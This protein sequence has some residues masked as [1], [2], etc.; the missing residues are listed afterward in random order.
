MKKF[1]V[2][3][4]KLIAKRQAKISINQRAFLFGD[5]FFETIKIC[6]HKI[7]NFSA[8]LRRI[9]KALEFL[10]FQAKIDDLEKNCEKLIAKNKVKNGLLR[11]HISRGDK[12]AG[13]AP[14]KNCKPLIIIETLKS[15]KL[16]KI[17][18]LGISS[19]CAPKINF[20]SGN[21]IFY[22]LNKLEAQKQKLFDLVMLDCEGFVS[23]TSSANIFWIKD[24]KIYTSSQS[25]N[26]ILGC[27]REKLLKN[28]NL[29]I[30]EK[31]AKIDEL[32]NADEIFLTNSSFLILPVDEF[33]GSKL[34]KETT[35]KLK[36]M[37][38]QDLKNS[39]K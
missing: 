28:F 21:A 6:N 9:K 37:L 18:S 26:I 23:E 30:I 3:N 1:I 11:I 32:K 24:E 5:A 39:C 29:K 4:Q 36:K 17:I 31:R 20:K 10:Q 13:Y 15:R 22:I 34:K 27:M 14:A 19:I 12:S 38:V 33:L 8:H 35:Q 2:K 7:Y 25:C 16:P